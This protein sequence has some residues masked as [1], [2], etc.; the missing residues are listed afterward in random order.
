MD[1]LWIHVEQCLGPWR[2]D[3]MACFITFDREYIP[4]PIVGKVWPSAVINHHEDFH[5]C[6]TNY[7]DYK[8]AQRE[9]PEALRE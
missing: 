1:S 8:H 2:C 3:N 6:F 7:C 9:F 4:T 5:I